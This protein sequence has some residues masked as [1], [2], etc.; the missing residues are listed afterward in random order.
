MSDDELITEMDPPQRKVPR[1]VRTKQTQQSL[2]PEQPTILDDLV[3]EWEPEPLPELPPELRT[4]V[5]RGEFTDLIETFNSNAIVFEG[6]IDS[7]RAG[8]EGLTKIVDENIKSGFSRTLAEH[9]TRLNE[10][11]AIQAQLIQMSQNIDACWRAVNTMQQQRG[12]AEVQ[13]DRSTR[14]AA[15]D[16]AIKTVKKEGE[17][18]DPAQ[19]TVLADAFLQWLRAVGP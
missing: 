18:V 9:E 3:K 13:M 16:L 14:S 7:V 6:A 8:V 1:R 19:V 12:I 5:T 2:L 17:A 15:L 11:T 10:L 4:D